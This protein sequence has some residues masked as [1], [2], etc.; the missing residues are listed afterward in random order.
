MLI[1]SEVESGEPM[2]YHL[3]L[4]GCLTKSKESAAASYVLLLDSQIGTGAAAFMALRVLKDHGVRE[5][6]IIFC[7]ILVSRVGGIWALRD[8]FPGV[9]IVASEVDDGLEERWCVVLSIFR[10]YRRR[11]FPR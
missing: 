9:R 1:Q 5:D 7:T 11:S 10:V 8:A 2:L 4:P 6:H 3:E